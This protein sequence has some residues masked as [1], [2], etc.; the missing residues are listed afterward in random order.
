MAAVLGFAG[1]EELIGRHNLALLA[2]ATP[3]EAEAA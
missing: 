3:T 2:V 1:P